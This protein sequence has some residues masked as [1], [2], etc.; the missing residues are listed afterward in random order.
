MHS[1]INTLFSS[2]RLWKGPDNV[3]VCMYVSQ[4]ILII[5]IMYMSRYGLSLATFPSPSSLVIYEINS[6]PRIYASLVFENERK[7]RKE[8][9]T[10][11]SRIYIGWDVWMRMGDVDVDVPLEVTVP[12][13]HHGI[14]AADVAKSIATDQMNC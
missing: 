12:I 5:Y 14:I 13:Q 1:H 8:K 3:Y 2:G 4:N 9:K 7:K 11:S 6:P 10:L